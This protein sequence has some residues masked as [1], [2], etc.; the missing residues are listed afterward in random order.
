M[1]SMVSDKSESRKSRLG[2]LNRLDKN[3]RQC[4]SREAVLNLL[5]SRSPDS[6]TPTSCEMTGT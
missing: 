6:S 2:G 5:A 3:E 4:A 1:R